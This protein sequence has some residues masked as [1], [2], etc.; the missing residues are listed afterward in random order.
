MER[1]GLTFDADN[2]YTIKLFL[3]Y[4]TEK[5]CKQPVQTSV[6]GL[7]SFLMLDVLHL[8]YGLLFEKLKHE[9]A[10]FSALCG[11]LVAKNVCHFL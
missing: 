4:A 8:L 7:P 11:S 6:S 10:V 3:L 1:V 2:S 5:L 9:K